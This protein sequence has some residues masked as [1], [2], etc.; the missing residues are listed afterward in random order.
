MLRILAATA[1]L[2]FSGA[3]ASAQDYPSRPIR[4]IIGLP[5]GGGADI[6]ARYFADKLK[7]AL[8]QTVVVENKP[9]AGGNLASQAVATADPDGDDFALHRLFLRGVGDDDAAGGLLVG[10][11]AL[12]DDAVVKRTKLHGVLLGLW[13][14]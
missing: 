2:I 4:I 10:V 6:I 11:Q 7:G 1:I 12:D 8:H 9:G 14:G 13:A 5:A 3:L